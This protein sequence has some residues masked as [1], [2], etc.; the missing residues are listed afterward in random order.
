VKFKKRG[1]TI[2]IVVKFHLEKENIMKKII[3][4][5]ILLCNTTTFATTQLSQETTERIEKVVNMSKKTMFLSGVIVASDY[6]FIRSVN[7]VLQYRGEYIETRTFYSGNEYKIMGIGSD[8]IT[9]LDIQIIDE[10][11]QI[12]IK[13]TQTD[14]LPSVV[15]NP[16]KTGKYTI[17]VIAYDIQE[18]L[19]QSDN[20]FGFSLGFK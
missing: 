4:G 8:G 6:K 11:G 3:V 2:L 13:D 12:V 19:K 16:T 10:A 15:F 5:L 14:N 17:K 9:D 18:S 7:D 1:D 20:L